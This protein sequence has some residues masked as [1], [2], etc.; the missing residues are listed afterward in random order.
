MA[1]ETETVKAS[2]TGSLQ[3]AARHCNQGVFGMDAKHSA[4]TPYSCFEEWEVEEVRQGTWACCS[5]ALARRRTAERTQRTHAYACN[6]IHEEPQFAKICTC[7]EIAG[8]EASNVEKNTWQA[9]E[10][11]APA[12]TSASIPDVAFP[13]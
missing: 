8:C 11:D 10:D 5:A 13:Q 6:V 7:L 12:N 1:I 4:Q 2:S 9:H 3:N